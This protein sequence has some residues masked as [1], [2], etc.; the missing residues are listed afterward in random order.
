ML[1]VMYVDPFNATLATGR[2][3]ILAA[4]ITFDALDML[5]LSIRFVAILCKPSGNVHAVMDKDKHFG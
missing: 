2:L 3:A 1:T 4:S 5:L